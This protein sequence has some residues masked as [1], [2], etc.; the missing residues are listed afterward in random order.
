[1][2]RQTIGVWCENEPKWSLEESAQ[3][4]KKKRKIDKNWPKLSAKLVVL[5]N[6][7]STNDNFIYPQVQ[8]MELKALPTQLKYVYLGENNTLLVII[9]REMT[10][11]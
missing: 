6:E 5:V 8:G 3:K 11:K 7:E 2:E 1:M 10:L 4:K 9:S